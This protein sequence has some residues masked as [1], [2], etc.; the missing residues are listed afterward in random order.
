MLTTVSFFFLHKAVEKDSGIKILAKGA[1]EAEVG[2]RDSQPFASLHQ[3]P[4]PFR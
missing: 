2:D 3:Q 1:T 4:Q